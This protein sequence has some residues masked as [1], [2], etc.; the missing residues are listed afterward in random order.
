MKEN[1]SNQ[2]KEEI[3][4]AYEQFDEDDTFSQDKKHKKIKLFSSKKMIKY[5]ICFLSSLSYTFII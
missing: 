2:N 3:E 5:I 4:R 1:V